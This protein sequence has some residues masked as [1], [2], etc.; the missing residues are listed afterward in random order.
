MTTIITWNIQWGLGVD[1]RV[2]LERIAAVIAAMGGADVLCLQEVGRHMPMAGGEDADQAKAL[3][4]LFPGSERVFGAAVD[5]AGAAGQRRRRFGNLILSRLPVLQAFRHPLPQPAAAGIKHMPRQATEAVIAAPWGPLRVTTTH[6]EFHTEA[7]RLAQAERLRAL[8]AEAA[9]NESAPA[10]AAADPMYGPAPRPA[11]GLIC[12]DLNLVPGDAA[13]RAFTAPFADATPPLID[14][15][16]HAK[17]GLAHAATC[18][19]Y[20]S[21]QWPQGAHC[22]DFFLLTPDLAERITD[23]AV[24]QRTDASD[25]QPVRLTLAD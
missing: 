16:R 24:D 9:A 8:H 23:I 2:D 6:L 10:Y 22:R 19:I 12:G 18:G 3:A 14:A 7:Q 17:P 25:H 21:A 15:W 11:S 5:R 1:G 4:A 13:Y 20:D